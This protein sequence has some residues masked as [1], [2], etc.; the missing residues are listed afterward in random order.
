M[1]PQATSNYAVLQLNLAWLRHQCRPVPW[2][3]FK[4]QSIYLHLCACVFSLRF[5]S[6]TL[7][8]YHS[9]SNLS[10][11]PLF[12]PPCSS[13]ESLKLCNPMDPN[14]YSPQDSFSSSSSSC[15]DS[16]TRMES[17]YS[18]FTSEHF[19]YQ[20]CTPQDCYCMPNCW[21]GQQESYSAPDYAPYYNPTDY[22]YACPVEENYFKRDFQMSS[23]MCYNVL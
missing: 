20:H 1:I 2:L 4:T 12:Q 5:S 9:S 14:S 23:E 13:P 22:S 3:R 18:G 19:H 6:V 16:P 21:P 8:F 11:S 7:A 17:S 10:S 15:Y